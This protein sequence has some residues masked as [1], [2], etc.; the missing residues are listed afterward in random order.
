[1]GFASELF[2]SFTAAGYLTRAG[3][4]AQNFSTANFTFI[5]FTKLT[6]HNNS[7]LQRIIYFLSS[8]G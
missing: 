8:M 3:F 2:I 6:S 5:S 4:D 7:L 1:M